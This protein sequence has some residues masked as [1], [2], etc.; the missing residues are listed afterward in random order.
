M[1]KVGSYGMIALR[2]LRCSGILLEAESYND[3]VVYSQQAI[4]KILK[5]YIH[6][7]YAGGVDAATLKSHKLLLL[8]RASGINELEPYRDVVS[9]ITDCYFD[10][11]YPGIDYTEYTRADAIRYNTVATEIVDLVTRKIQE[12]VSK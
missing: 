10:A 7:G 12:F 3:S 11:R 4:E 9:T 6:A 2:D 5:H 8:L 1:F